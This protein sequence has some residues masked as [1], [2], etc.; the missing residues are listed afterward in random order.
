MR[1]RIGERKLTKFHIVRKPTYR[2]IHEHL[3]IKR[4]KS[5]IQLREHKKHVQ[6]K[7]VIDTC[8]GPCSQLEKIEFPFDGKLKKGHTRL[9]ILLRCLPRLEMQRRRRDRVCFKAERSS[10]LTFSSSERRT[11]QF[12]YEKD[13]IDIQNLQT[14]KQTITHGE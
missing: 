7:T 14:I 10:D 1:K 2:K 9:I 5:K 3:A 11:Y 12:A 13:L 4:E 8:F 6:H